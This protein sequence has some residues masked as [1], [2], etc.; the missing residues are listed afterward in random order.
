[1]IKSLAFALL[2]IVVTSA[3]MTGEFPLLNGE[4]LDGKKIVL[5]SAC[6]GKKTI[7]GMAYSQKAQDALM[8]WYEPMFEKFVA[9][10]GMFDYE[11]DVN[12]YFVPM[13]I[14]L[15]QGLYE[16]T[17]KELRGQ[18]RKDLYPYV[19]FYKGELAPF[20]TQLNMQDKS[21]AYFFVLNEKGQVIHATKGAFSESKMEE[22]E[23]FL[24]KK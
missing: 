22:I 18:N 19:L 3:T 9:K 23:A 12:L 5:P 20:D 1:M 16:S 17:L 7:I 21:Q 24:S 8:S 15:K 14:G 11:Y 13:F 2:C 10:V 4:T 6:I